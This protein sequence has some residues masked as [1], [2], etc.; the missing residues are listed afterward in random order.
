MKEINHIGSF[1]HNQN[2]QV[3][4]SNS[5]I[6][7]FSGGF[8]GNFSGTLTGSF[9]GNFTGSLSGTVANISG[10]NLIINGTMEID[11]RKEGVSLSIDAELWTLDR[12][13]TRRGGTGI[14]SAIR[15]TTV[16]ARIP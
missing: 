7:T 12:W 14:F 11:Q 16:P 2:S 8:N 9:L 4:Y 5:E 6:G 1:T 15:S 13:K 10:K 3:E